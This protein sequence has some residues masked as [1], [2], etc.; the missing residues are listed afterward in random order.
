MGHQC[1]RRCCGIA[2][3][4]RRYRTVSREAASLLA[5]LPP[6]DLEATVL[7]RM[8]DQRVEMQ[9][10]GE[11]PLP[12]HVEAWRKELRRD[13]KVKWKQRLS[14]PSARHTIISAVVPL[15]EAWL[16]RP[17]GVLTFR[18]TQVLTGHGKFGK[19][20]HR[21]RAEETSGCRHCEA[22]PED[23]VE[24]SVEVCFAWE[25]HRRVLVDRR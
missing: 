25:E 23:T 13:L 6:W 3:R 10:R 22:S 16:D 8:H 20:L 2:R 21:I 17:H 19:F 5:G 15:F 1:G 9:R 11:T 12:E 4:R 18:M 7:A 14:Q 24:H